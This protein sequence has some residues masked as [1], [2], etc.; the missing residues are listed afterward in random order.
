ML[1]SRGARKCYEGVNAGPHAAAK[2]PFRAQAA[3]GTIMS[4]LYR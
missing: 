1:R 2:V 3:Y 4:A